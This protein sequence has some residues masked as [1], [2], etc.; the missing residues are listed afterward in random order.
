VPVHG[1]FHD[2]QRPE[3]AKLPLFLQEV[4]PHAIESRIERAIG[5][6]SSDKPVIRKR[7][8]FGEPRGAV[9][10]YR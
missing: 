7:E 10:G 5:R 9:M 3:L 6:L 8:V 1:A 4:P 2:S